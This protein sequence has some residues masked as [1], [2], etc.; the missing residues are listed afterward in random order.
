MHLDT[1]FII[2]AQAKSK[3]KKEMIYIANAS[4]DWLIGD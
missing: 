1:T 2:V 3:R 4:Y